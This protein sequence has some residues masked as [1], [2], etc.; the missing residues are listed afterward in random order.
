MLLN[1]F[2]PQFTQYKTEIMIIALQGLHKDQKYIQQV[3]Y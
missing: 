3:Y 1:Q 2:K